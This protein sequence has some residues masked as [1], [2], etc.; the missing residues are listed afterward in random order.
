M[1]LRSNIRALFAILLAVATLAIAP[2]AWAHGSDH[3]RSVRTERQVN[4]GE[5]THHH[6]RAPQ[7][8]VTVQALSATTIGQLTEARERCGG[9]M[10]CGSVCLSCC[11]L[12][13]AE[14]SVPMPSIS[15]KRLKVVKS[16]PQTGRGS[17]QVRRP[18]KT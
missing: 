1:C 15:A 13:T 18:P 12:L 2:E 9:S 5:T 17:E 7:I 16:L 8:E 10:C 4:I 3:P 14:L 11:S 6:H